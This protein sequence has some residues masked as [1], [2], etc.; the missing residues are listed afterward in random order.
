[1]VGG[2][3]KYS[4]P[5][6]RFSAPGS[7]TYSAPP[8]FTLVRVFRVSGSRNELENL[9]NQVP[10]VHLWTARQLGCQCLKQRNLQSEPSLAL[11]FSNS[12]TLDCKP[13]SCCSV[14]LF[15]TIPMTVSTAQGLL[16]LRFLTRLSGTVL[17]YDIYDVINWNRKTKWDF[18]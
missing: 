3:C 16:N 13:L 1:M 2:T 18:T 10:V 5:F 12:R 8:P 7:V 15:A 6:S 17:G 9:T 4:S 14:A 11:P